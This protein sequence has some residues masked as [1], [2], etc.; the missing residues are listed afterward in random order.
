MSPYKLKVDRYNSPAL[1]SRCSTFCSC[2]A[3]RGDQQTQALVLLVD[4]ARSHVQSE[5]EQHTSTDNRATLEEFVRIAL[6][7]RGSTASSSR[8]DYKT[9]LCFDRRK[10]LI[11]EFIKQASKKKCA[12]C[13]AHAAR[14]KKEGHTKLVEYRRHGP[15]TAI[16]KRGQGPL[17]AMC[18]TDI[19]ADGLS[20]VYSYYDPE[21][22]DRS[23]GT[24]MI[25][26]H[27][28]RT[29]L[30]GLPHLYLGYWVEGSRKMGY[31]SR[32]LPQERLGLNG[33]DRIG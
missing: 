8:D 14:L 11:A 33:W 2:I 16:T 30:Q 20:M 27:I 24:F 12:R 31:K 7:G 6:A 5:Y 22:A 17:V 25:L 9:S 10:R 13:G 3:A 23:L 1:L 19:L 15:D 32:F 18:L 29:R 21:Q 4:R 28:E 26:D